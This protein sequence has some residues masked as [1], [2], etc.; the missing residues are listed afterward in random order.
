MESVIVTVLIIFLMGALVFL[1]LLVRPVV[2]FRSLESAKEAD[3]KQ[4]GFFIHFVVPSL[5]ALCFVASIALVGVL[6]KDPS[7]AVVVML[8]CG[9]VLLWYRNRSSKKHVAK[10]TENAYAILGVGRRADLDAIKAAFERK[11]EQPI[12]APSR[13]RLELAYQILSQE[14]RRFAYDNLVKDGEVPKLE[15]AWEL[16]KGEANREAYRAFDAAKG[17]KSV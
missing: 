14:E 7:S 2:R 3:K 13:E 15:T 16:V 17:K 6:L 10:H 1:V 8:C 12:E 9:V 5:L 11:L 4:V